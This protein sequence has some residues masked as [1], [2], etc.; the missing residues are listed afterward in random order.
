MLD[1]ISF[2]LDGKI[3]TISF[4]ETMHLKPTTTVLQYLRG[5]PDHKGVKEGCAEGDCGACTVVLAEAHPDEQKLTYKAVN[6]CLLFLPK[7]H[8]KQLITIENLK[9]RNGN[10]HPVQKTLAEQNGS[11]C[12][13]CTPG[14][15]MSLFGHFKSNP[16][17][18]KDAIEDTLSGNLCR[19]TGYQP[20]LEAGQLVLDGS[21]E[22]YFNTEEK[23]VWDKLNSISRDSVTIKTDEQI[24]HLPAN[25]D[26][27][28]Q[29]K[30]KYPQALI[31]DGSTDV[32]LRVTKQ[33][34]LLP[35]IIDLSNVAELRQT[36]NGPDELQV[37]AGVSI[38]ALMQ[39][40]KDD[41]PA[42]YSICKTF[43]SN[44]IRNLATVGGNLGSASPIG[45]LAPVLLAYRATVNVQS[46]RGKRS[47]A[48]DDF[49]TGYR[50]TALSKDE[51]ITGIEIPVPDENIIIKAYKI[52]KRYDLDIATVSAGFKIELDNNI[53][54]HCVLAFGGMAAQTSRAK[55]AEQFL[56]GKTWTRENAEQCMEIVR[57]LFTP[58]SD[59]RSGAEFRSLVAGNLVLKFWLESQE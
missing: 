43:G 39:L 10:L 31:I 8:G 26:E 27:T 4:S 13:F 25:L 53:I 16:L 47:I 17:Q 6:S 15:V 59:A 1:K 45:D 5:L 34:E 14:I 2:I 57:E 55:N 19:C 52:S 51:I 18:D 21:R 36:K 40:A 30:S 48:M 42:V 35:L 23:Q 46:I 9:D 20:I 29:L 7:L 54:K 24:Y 12:G 44:Q 32:A 37:G 33:H 49:I 41:F 56:V 22:D 58:I 50:K 11:Q 38:N 28:L 3:K